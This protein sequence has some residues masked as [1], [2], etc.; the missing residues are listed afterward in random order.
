MTKVPI[1]LRLTAI[2]NFCNVL[3]V[4]S[5]GRCPHVSK[6]KGGFGNQIQ[7]KSR[8]TEGGIL[9][10]ASVDPTITTLYGTVSDN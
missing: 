10:D 2:D 3:L 5:Y 6:A 8:S 7:C 1:L 9:G 4:Y